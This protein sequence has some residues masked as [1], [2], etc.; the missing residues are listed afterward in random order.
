MIL[1]GAGYDTRNEDQRH[2]QTRYGHSRNFEVRMNVP[3]SCSQHALMSLNKLKIIGIWGMES[4]HHGKP[5]ASKTALVKHKR[6]PFHGTRHGANVSI[7]V[8]SVPRCSEN[9]LQLLGELLFYP[10]C[11]WFLVVLVIFPFVETVD[12]A[13]NWQD[14]HDPRS[15]RNDPQ[16]C[17]ALKAGSL[18]YDSSRYPW[19]LR[20]SS[21]NCPRN[22][23]WHQNSHACKDAVHA[24]WWLLMI[25]F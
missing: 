15:Y 23:F 21:V 9:S 18:F 3:S 17:H 10:K 14:S 22:L 12:S 25:L 24:C 19:I 8:W 13:P 4:V 1:L 6:R 2:D 20:D 11:H 7:E 5:R 16:C